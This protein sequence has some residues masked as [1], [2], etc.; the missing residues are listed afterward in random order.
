MWIIRLS[1]FKHPASA[2]K[3]LIV[4]LKLLL[5]IFSAMLLHLCAINSSFRGNSIIIDLNS[6]VSFK[7]VVEGIGL[8]LRTDRTCDWTS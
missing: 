1:G 6:R 2:S 7:E 4:R 5:Q 8:K 3:S